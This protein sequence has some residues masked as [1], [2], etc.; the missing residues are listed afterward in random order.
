MR[1]VYDGNNTGFTVDSTTFRA[2]HRYGAALSGVGTLVA[3][4]AY[5][6]GGQNSLVGLFLGWAGPLGVFYFGGAYLSEFTSHR[7][8][9]EE[10]LRGVAWYFGSL[11]AWAVIVT[12]TS[13]LTSSPFT[14]FGLPALTALGI[15]LAMVATRYVTGRDLTVQTAGGQ[16]LVWVTG[17]VAF[18]FLALYLVL[19][20][21]AG[22]WLVGA[23]LAS[24]PV[25]L[26]LW[27]VMIQRYPDA[28]GV[29]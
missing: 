2:I 28:F 14:V 22:W 15:S 23:Y 6:V 8:V 27:W 9:G 20:D 1:Q 24:I 3:I 5:A 4:L 17:V 7:V 29:D 13:A 12:E 19:A 26:A 21:R 16:L 11:V 18:G 25:G 10:L